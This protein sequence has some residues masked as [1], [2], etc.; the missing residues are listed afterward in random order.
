LSPE[1]F[2]KTANPDINS[3][4]KAS[5]VLYVNTDDVAATAT[6][7]DILPVHLLVSEF[8]F[9]YREKVL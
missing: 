3:A 5:E 7:F 9:E 4:T 6:L 8:V 2:V 1:I